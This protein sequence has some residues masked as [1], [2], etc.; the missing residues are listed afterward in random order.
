MMPT[1]RYQALLGGAQ[2]ANVTAARFALASDGVMQTS[3][4]GRCDTHTHTHTQTHR[5]L[6]LARVTWHAFL[7]AQRSCLVTA[8]APLCLC[9]CVCVCVCRFAHPL[10]HTRVSEGQSVDMSRPQQPLLPVSHSC[11]SVTCYTG[12]QMYVLTAVAA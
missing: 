8:C 2:T 12:R 10:W 4:A 1:N 7:P 5:G 9:V 6:V 11:H 3:A